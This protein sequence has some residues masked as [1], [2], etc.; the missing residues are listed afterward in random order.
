M[1]PLQDPVA[2]G[3]KPERRDRVPQGLAEGKAREEAQKERQQDFS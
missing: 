1:K 3:C 2:A